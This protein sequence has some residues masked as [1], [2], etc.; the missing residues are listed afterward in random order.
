MT[1]EPL[2]FRK[3]RS[4]LDECRERGLFQRHE[5]L[6]AENADLTSQLANRKKVTSAEV[7]NIAAH[8]VTSA[9]FADALE[10]CRNEMRTRTSQIFDAFTRA[11]MGTEY[12]PLLAHVLINTDTP[13][14]EAE[15]LFR[16][17]AI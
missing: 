15:S 17:A 6:L 13:G 12:L 7:H 1:D 5:E 3:R 16:V 10:A 11:G 2:P 8:S 9:A 4:Y 14:D